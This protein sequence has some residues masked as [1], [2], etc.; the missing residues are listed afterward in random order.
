VTVSQGD[1][2]VDAVIADGTYLARIVHPNDWAIPAT[3]RRRWSVPMTKTGHFW[4]GSA[5]SSD[6]PERDGSASNCRA[7]CSCAGSRHD[8]S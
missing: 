6:L 7:S 8:A 4:I 2:T 3:I 5:P 1:D